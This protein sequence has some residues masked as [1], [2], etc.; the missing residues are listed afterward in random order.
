MITYL[1]YDFPLGSVVH[2][3]LFLHGDGEHDKNPEK[4]KENINQKFCYLS[5]KQYFLN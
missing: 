3:P 5:T 1:Q 2:C 4:M